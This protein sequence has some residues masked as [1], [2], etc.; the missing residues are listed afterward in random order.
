MGKLIRNYDFTAY[1]DPGILE[2][3]DVV[4]GDRTPSLSMVACPG[5]VSTIIMDPIAGHQLIMA[6]LGLDKV[7]EGYIT[8]DGELVTYGSGA[9]FRQ[10]MCYV[11]C[12]L[13]MVDMT[14][15][16]LCSQVVNKYRGK[17]LR[18]EDLADTWKGLGVDP[19]IWKERLLRVSRTS[20]WLVL[21]SLVLFSRAS[22]VLIEEPV[23]TNMAVN[24]FVSQLAQQGKAVICTTQS[25]IFSSFQV[26]NLTSK[27]E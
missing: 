8:V 10:M 26:V 27:S 19:S 6:I 1:K 24:A 9:F 17:S 18:V 22:I 23:V 12:S 4:I 16:E 11:P 14:V 2:F 21:L 5:K 25:N 7:K 13:P 3:K 15:G 20:L